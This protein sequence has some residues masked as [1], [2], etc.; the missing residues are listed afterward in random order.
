MKFEVTK[1]GANG[2]TVGS[3]VEIDGDKVP[4]WLENK[5]HIVEEKMMIVNPEPV[6]YGKAELIAQAKELGVEVRSQWSVKRLQREIDAK[7]AV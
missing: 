5:G 3:L 6:F 1:K 4:A 2:L 7:L